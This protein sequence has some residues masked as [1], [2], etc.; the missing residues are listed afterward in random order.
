MMWLYL[1]IAFYAGIFA[2]FI[3]FRWLGRKRSYSGIINV[4]RNPDK[5]LFSLELQEDPEMIA[6]QDEVVFKVVTKEYKDDRG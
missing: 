2:G 1:V 3:L 5:T 4:I 6:Y